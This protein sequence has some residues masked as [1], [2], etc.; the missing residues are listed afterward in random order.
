MRFH[1]AGRHDAHLPT[2][3]RSGTSVGT[4]RRFWRSTPPTGSARVSAWRVRVPAAGL[5]Q[6]GTVRRR[7]GCSRRVGA[8]VLALAHRLH[9][10]L[11]RKSLR[12][13]PPGAAE[14][15]QAAQAGV[16]SRSGALPEL[17]W[18][19]EDHCGDPGAAGDREDPHAPGAAGARATAGAGPVPGAASGLTIPIH[20]RSGGPQSRATGIGCARGFSGPMDVARRQ[21]VTRR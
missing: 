10:P 13:P 11:L 3:H 18:R 14:L 21:G 6:P 15:G 4:P 19:S 12:T 5:H 7:L 20:H 9:C 16:R 2:R 1:V 8:R 17:R